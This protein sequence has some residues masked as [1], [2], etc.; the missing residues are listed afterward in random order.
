MSTDR[1]WEFAAVVDGLDASLYCGPLQIDALDHPRGTRDDLRGG[2]HAVGDEV[3]DHRI[4]DAELARSGLQ[5]QPGAIMVVVGELPTISHV[6]DMM[7]APRLALAGPVSS[8]MKT[9][10]R[11]TFF[12]WETSSLFIRERWLV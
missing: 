12:R 11:R 7:H 9:T 4:T 1:T 3:L 5:G 8:S 2:Q 6:P 10:R